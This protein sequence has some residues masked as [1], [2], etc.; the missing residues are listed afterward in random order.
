VGHAVGAQLEHPRR[1]DIQLVDVLEAFADP[2]RLQLL[3]TLDKADG[4]MSCGEIPLPVSKSTGSHHYKVLRE[5]GC[6]EAR[7]EGTRRY[8]T[9]RRDDL[10]ARFPGL[11]DA[12][13]HAEGRSDLR[14]GADDVEHLAAGDDHRHA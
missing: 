5:A 2:I 4:A 11:L 9:V 8:Y 6:I 1:D 3:R 14:G 12:V 7:T 10:D 13:L